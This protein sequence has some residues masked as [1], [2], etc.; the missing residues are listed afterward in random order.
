M[1]IYNPEDFSLIEFSTIDELDLINKTCD[2]ED[3]MEYANFT[4]WNYD[5]VNGLNDLIDKHENLNLY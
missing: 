3:V 4:N 2:S 5:I 1:K